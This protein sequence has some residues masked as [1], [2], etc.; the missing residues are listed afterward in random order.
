M[1]PV[2]IEFT[3]S[4]LAVPS[5]AAPVAT[6]SA[7]PVSVERKDAVMQNPTV[8]HLLEVFPVEKTTVQDE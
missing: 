1:R 2:K 6:A 7:G 3:D 8:Q 4:G 5:P